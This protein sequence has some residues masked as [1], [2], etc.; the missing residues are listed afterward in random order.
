MR[1]NMRL[2]GVL[3][4]LLMIG[5]DRPL[6]DRTG[7]RAVRAGDSSGGARLRSLLAAGVALCGHRLHRR[8]LRPPDQ[9]GGVAPARV[10]GRCRG[11]A[12]HPQSARHRRCAQEDRRLAAARRHHPRRGRGGRPHADR[13]ALRPV[14]RA[15][16]HPPADPGTHP[17]PRARFRPGAA[18]THHAGTDAAAQPAAP[19]DVPPTPAGGVAGAAA[20]HGDRQHRQ[21]RRGAAHR[22]HAAA[23]IDPAGAGRGRALAAGGGGRGT[24]PGPGRRGRGA[25]APAGTHPRTGADGA[26]GHV[27]AL[28]G[29]GRAR[30][31][32]R[33]PAAAATRRD[34][35]PGTAPPP[36]RPPAR[37]D[38]AD[39]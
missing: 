19:I 34:R 18:Q 32:A 29:P 21:P 33:G 10:P 13:R 23:C 28:R 12:V 35:L 2:I 4:G 22:R 14:R 27:R 36:D 11:G 30:G 7:A 25:H 3:F 39:R 20:V 16:R 8:V 24:G 9:G 1:L 31:A 37:A 17:H 15:V 38:R 26:A 6:P 5:D